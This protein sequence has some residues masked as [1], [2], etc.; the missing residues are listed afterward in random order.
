VNIKLG[1]IAAFL[2]FSTLSSTV[3][4]AATSSPADDSAPAATSSQEKILSLFNPTEVTT[5]SRRKEDSFSAAA[6][7]YVITQEDIKRSGATNVP[8]AL[9]LAP[10]VDVARSGSERYAVSIRGFNDNIANKL[11]VMV[12]GRTVYTPTFSGVNWDTV[13]PPL[14]DIKQIEIIR[15]PGGTLWGANAVNGV[16]NIITEDAQNTQ[17]NLISGIAGTETRNIYGRNGGKIGDDAFYRIYAQA[18]DYS[19][20][21]AENGDHVNDAWDRQQSGFRIDWGKTSQD[22]ITVQ[23]DVYTGTDNRTAFLP[24]PTP[25]PFVNPTVDDANLHGGNILGRWTH[26]YADGAQ[27]QLQVYFDNWDRLFDISEEKVNT[28]DF[29]LQHS[30]LA[31]D[32]NEI[33]MGMGYRL[34]NYDEPAR[35]Y[36]LYNPTQDDLNLYSTFIQDKF[37]IIRDKVFFT[38]GSKFEVNDFTGFEYEPSAR[39][40]WLIDERQTLWAAISRA[41]RT[42][43]IADETIIQTVGAIPN[44]GY[45]ALVSNKD[46]GSEDL[47]AHEIGYRIRPNSDITIDTTAFYNNYTN[48]QTLDFG[49]PF[50]NI[51]VP[52]V[53]HNYGK[54]TSYGF[55][56]ASTWKVTSKWQLTGSYSYIL[57][58]TSLE[59]GST[60]TSLAQDPGKSPKN[61]FN[62][63]SHLNLPYD[64]EMDN[65]VYYVDKLDSI[66]IP[67][68]I[69][70]D[71]KF[72]WHCTDNVELSL[73][74]QNLLTNEHREFVPIPVLEE[75]EIAR[76]IYAQ[77]KVR[78]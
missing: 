24:V 2:S 54:A 27:T 35:A 50:G 25:P 8:E 55:E 11:L 16:I 36:F 78:F 34:V 49:A 47:I 29:D 44:A 72:T 57:L 51:A 61:Q 53:D 22:N 32:R 30:F 66:D 65:M 17:E 14:E 52:L 12:D 76:S 59:S 5:V 6:A 1:F 68:Y 73:V 33:T 31:G 56:L 48:L 74:G 26:S 64:T 20:T 41:V 45:V 3:F 69:R 4:A 42:P 40:S 37:A 19:H 43:S 75:S 15:G 9:R 46:Y 18:F 23:G 63:R 71:S 13:T 21:K 58:H 7:I 39:L 77:A 62:I 67:A 10:G 28:L 70:F 60:D 38:F